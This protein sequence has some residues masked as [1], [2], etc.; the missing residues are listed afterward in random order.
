MWIP[1]SQSHRGVCSFFRGVP[2]RDLLSL[3]VIRRQR[4][5][6]CRK[7]LVFIGQRAPDEFSLY[8]SV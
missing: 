4:T 3:L 2:G 1:G 5:K 7:P 6:R 8:A